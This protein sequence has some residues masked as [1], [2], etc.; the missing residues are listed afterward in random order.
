V[1][2][3]LEVAICDP[4]SSINQALLVTGN[5]VLVSVEYLVKVELDMMSGVAKMLAPGPPGSVRV[6]GEIAQTPGID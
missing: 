2:I 4:F 6:T 5:W 3:R 1:P